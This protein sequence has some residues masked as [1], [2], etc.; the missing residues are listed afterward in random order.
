MGR[1]PADTPIKTL[2]RL[3][4]MR[5]RIEHHPPKSERG[6]LSLYGIL[7]ER[8]RVITAYFDTAPTAAD[9]PT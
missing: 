1:C 6:S 7:K 2:V 9:E 5:W 4:K 3:A 8:Q